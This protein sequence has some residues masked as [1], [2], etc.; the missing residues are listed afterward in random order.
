MK[1]ATLTLWFGATG[2]VR[3]TYDTT[4]HYGGVASLSVTPLAGD[5]VTVDA[6]V[7]GVPAPENL[8]TVCAPHIVRQEARHA[9]DLSN[10]VASVCVSVDTSSDCLEP[11]SEVELLVHNTRAYVSVFDPEGYE[12]VADELEVDGFTFDAEGSLHET[13]SLTGTCLGGAVEHEVHATWAFEMSDTFKE[14]RT[15]W[16]D[17]TLSF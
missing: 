7:P 17:P 10:R 6:E 8:G 14:G 13:F 5:G 11:G 15:E 4:I 9:D 3:W 1:A 16:W 12:T 2:C